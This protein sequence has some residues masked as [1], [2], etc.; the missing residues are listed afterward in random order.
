MKPPRR[1]SAARLARILD[2]ARALIRESNGIGFTM[3]DVAQRAGV[4]P[5]TPYNLLGSKDGLL[6]ALLSDL[7]D[8]LFIGVLKYRASDPIEHPVE[9]AAIG[10]EVFAADS[11]VLR[12]LLAVFLGTRDELHRPWF[13]H[14]SF[15]FWRHSLEAAIRLKRIPPEEAERDDLARL[16]MLHFVGCVNLWVHG[17]L[18]DEGF[19]AQVVYG[20]CR[21]MLG[22]ADEAGRKRLNARIHEAQRQLPRHHSFL[23]LIVPG[24]SMET[25]AARAALRIE[26]E[27]R[28]A[29]RRPSGAA[30]KK[31]AARPKPS[32]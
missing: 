30:R 23:R 17:D 4:A 18:D 12:E 32:K 9:A 14:R 7:L 24:A 16:L 20:T 28:G 27:A 3:K 19:Q 15:T 2:A 6:Y 22:F 21:I 5:A 1:Q 11:V 10:A 13:M 8:G 26:S 25:R 29:P 31:R